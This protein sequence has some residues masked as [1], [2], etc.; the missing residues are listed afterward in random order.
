MSPCNENA[1]L[2]R[3]MVEEG[4]KLEFIAM[5]IGVTKQAIWQ[6]LRRNDVQGPT[7]GE[8]AARRRPSKWGARVDPDTKAKI[9]AL[10]GVMRAAKVVE[11]FGLENVDQVYRIWF[12]AKRREKKAAT[13]KDVDD[14]KE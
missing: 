5:K 13:Q 3:K 1:D 7:Q 12:E 10:R 4:H 2:I 11:D 14:A 9:K 6:F 8:A